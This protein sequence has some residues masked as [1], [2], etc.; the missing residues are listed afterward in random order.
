MVEIEGTKYMQIKTKSANGY[1]EL[2][3]LRRPRGKAIYIAFRIIA[4]GNYHRVMPLE[5]MGGMA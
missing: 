5:R 3:Y 1:E 2:C 4:T